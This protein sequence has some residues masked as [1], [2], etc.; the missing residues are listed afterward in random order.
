MS[1]RGDAAADQRSAAERLREGAER[2]SE[3]SDSRG[4]ERSG[5][6]A[7]RA[8]RKQTEPGERNDALRTDSIDARQRT[9]STRV[10]AEVEADGPSTA[11][12][13][14]TSDAEASRALREAAPS[15]ERTLENQGVPARYRDLVRRYFRHEGQRSREPEGGEL[16][17]DAGDDGGGGGNSDGGGGGS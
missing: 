5:R 17:P 15:A 13:G 7:D 9:D 8:P 14:G 4:G 10:R 11:R 2:V 3:R 6:L 1:D 12:R 16:A